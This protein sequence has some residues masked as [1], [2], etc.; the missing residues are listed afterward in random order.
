MLKYRRTTHFAI[1]SFSLLANKRII[2]RVL[3]L[4]FKP[5]CGMTAP[6]NIL[7]FSLVS[8]LPPILLLG[9]FNCHNSTWVGVDNNAKGLKVASFL[10]Q[11]NL[12]LLNKKDTIYILSATESLSSII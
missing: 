7:I 6:L 8:Q 11:S 9:D 1:A 3:L 2:F 10:L 5:R 12:C 4:Q